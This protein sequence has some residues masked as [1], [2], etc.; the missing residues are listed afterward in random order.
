[1][2]LG[3]AKREEKTKDDRPTWPKV[4]RQKKALKIVI[5]FEGGIELPKLTI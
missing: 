1:M 3:R 5:S 2:N 4:D